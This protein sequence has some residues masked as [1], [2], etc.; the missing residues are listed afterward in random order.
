MMTRESLTRVATALCVLLLLSAC[1]AR[2]AVMDAAATPPYPQQAAQ[3]PD[4]DIVVVRHGD[5]I[6]LVNRTP[7][8]YD[9]MELWLN[10]TYV[11]PIDHVAI[12]QDNVIALPEFINAYGEPYP[13]GSFLRPDRSRQL[14][15]AEFHDREHGLR[16]RLVVQPPGTR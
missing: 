6:R 10:Q 16:H 13:V 12:G 14:V 7:R 5:N 15:L 1:T 8:T 11:R 4:L 9:N 3:G 2:T